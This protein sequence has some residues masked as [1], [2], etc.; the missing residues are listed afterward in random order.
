MFKRLK[1][2]TG[3]GQYDTSVSSDMEQNFVPSKGHLKSDLFEFMWITALRKQ[4]EVTCFGSTT[5]TITQMAVCCRD[6]FH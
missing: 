1:P 6:V 4:I 3:T 2:E 5:V